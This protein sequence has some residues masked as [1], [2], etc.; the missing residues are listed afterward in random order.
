[1]ILQ[2]DNGR[3]FVAEVIHQVMAMWSGVVIVHGRPRHPQSQGSVERANQDV[4]PMI[5]NWMKDNNTKNWVLGLNF[6]QIAKNTRFHSGVG[7]EPY[8]LQYGQICRYGLADLPVDKEVLA[9]LR[10]EDE[11]NDLMKGISFHT[12]RS[13][14]A[15]DPV[16]TN[17]A[18]T[19][20]S[21]EAINVCNTTAPMM[22]SLEATNPVNTTTTASAASLEGTNPID[23][24]TAAATA[25]L[26]P[27]CST[28][29]EVTNTTNTT[30][31]AASSPEVT[32]AIST[33]TATTA[34]SLEAVNVCVKCKHRMSPDY[35]CKGEGCGRS[36]H[37]FCSEGNA[38]ENEQKG[39][40]KH[41]WCLT[42]FQKHAAITLPSEDTCRLINEAKKGSDDDDNAIEAEATE[43]Y[44]GEAAAVNEQEKENMVP[45][46]HDTPGRGTKRLNARLKQ[47]S[48]GRRMQ[49]RV[50]QDTIQDVPVGAVCLVPIDKTDRCKIDPK[51]LPC[52]V[53]EVTPRG[54]Y[55]LAC[56][57]GVL[58]KVLCR[59]D[60]LHEPLKTPIFYG[61]QAALQNWKTMRKVSVRTGS[62]AIAPSGGQGHVHCNCSGNCSTKRCGSVTAGQ[63]CNSRCHP[64]NSNKCCNK[65][66]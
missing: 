23:T 59:Q 34:A 15:T 9:K 7:S 50:R 44:I 64:S 14:E 20:A 66:N 60:F 4:E 54:Q 55:R 43:F 13:P 32:N 48:Q 29:L 6:V 39:H 22:A 49:K 31:A 11:L 17:T 12:A 52:V 8:K 51:R 47:V 61:L 53:V 26:K 1:M 30:T 38:E 16:N 57:E 25:S 40:G 58:N 46:A 63:K 62:G 5:G 36:I 19:A 21:L 42:C 2:S 18:A 10:N 41:Y 35:L 33:A 27:I 28:S 65:C 45:S 56:T 37:W 3:E 24:T